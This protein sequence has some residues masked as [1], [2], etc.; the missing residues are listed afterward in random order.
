MS[1]YI[2][3]YMLSILNFLWSFFLINLFEPLF[4]L[5]GCGS[6][7]EE[8]TSPSATASGGSG[9][10]SGGAEGS[11]TAMPSGAGD[12]GSSDPVAGDSFE[13]TEEKEDNLAMYLLGGAVAVAVGIG[14]Y[15]MLARRR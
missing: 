7:D 9:T 15:S 6:G 5:N 4:S 1:D 2:I 14:A 10:S 12:G 8:G 3:E 13:E 11:D